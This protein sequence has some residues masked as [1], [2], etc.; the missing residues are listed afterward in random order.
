MISLWNSALL[1]ILSIFFVYTDMISG[2]V[3]KSTDRK[4]IGNYINTS[5]T[6]INKCE[7]LLLVFALY[8]RKR[9]IFGFWTKWAT[10]RWIHIKLFEI[11]MDIFHYF[12]T[13]YRPDHSFNNWENKIIWSSSAAGNI[14]SCAGWIVRTEHHVADDFKIAMWD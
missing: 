12:L 7:D 5:I 10:C 9:N 6:A 14:I 8:D 13:F 11:V 1:F 3:E 2:F 4:W